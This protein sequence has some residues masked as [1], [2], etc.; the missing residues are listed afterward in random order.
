MNRR[1]TIRTLG[2]VAALAAGGYAWRERRGLTRADLD[3]DASRGPLPRSTPPAAVDA[4]LYYASLAPSG[5]NAQPWTVRA[6]DGE[7][8]IGTDRSRW[9]PKV[10]PSNRELAL[11]V[12]AFLENLLVA[13]PNHGYLAEYAVTAADGGADELLRVTLRRTPVVP[14]PLERIRNRRTLRSGQLPQA[15]S[16]DDVRM[17][18]TD[19]RNEAHFVTPTSREGRYLAEG[20]IEANRAQALRDDAQEE[21]AA[22]IRWTNAEARARRDGLTPESMEISGVA[23]WYVRHFMNRA[24]VMSSRFRDQG[25]DR[26]RDQ[27]AAC[28]GWVVVTSQDSTLPTLVETGRRTERMWLAVRDR[29][30][31]IHP[32][33]Q[34]LEEVPFRNAV[35]GDLGVTGHVQFILRVGYVKRYPDPV[36]LRRP[37]SSTLRR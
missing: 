7:L 6:G 19:C 37:M 14:A 8:R 21:L 5:H 20:T 11:S 18:T 27:V 12:G 30:I 4:I 31:A 13:A 22:W 23:G 33:S 25:L 15:L 29:S 17:L 34:M 10:D 3:A 26:V 24:T 35:A 16:H 1:Q 2:G 32:M 9:L 28:G 36:S